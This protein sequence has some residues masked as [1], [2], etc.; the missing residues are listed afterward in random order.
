[1]RC[2]ICGAKLEKENADICL[3]CY[4]DLIKKMKN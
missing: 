1:M 4:N 2:R 3:N